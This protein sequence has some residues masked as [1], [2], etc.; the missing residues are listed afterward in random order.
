M[1][2]LLIISRREITG[3][4][5]PTRFSQSLSL[6]YVS[7]KPIAFWWELCEMLRRFLL[8]GIAINVQQ[9]SIVQLALPILVSLCY[10]VLQLQT[11]RA[12]G[13]EPPAFR[14]TLT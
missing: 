3:K 6:L 7:Y 13:L 14:A 8:V 1:A 5:P 9:G 10:L 2:A 4:A 11:V 12:V